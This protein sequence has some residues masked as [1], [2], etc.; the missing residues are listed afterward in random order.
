MGLAE[1]ILGRDELSAARLI[2]LIENGDDEAY[3][4]IAALF[5][6]AG[7]AHVIGITGPA[8]AG[9]STIT[10]KLA[11]QYAKSGRKVG[12]LAVDPTSVHGG[13]ALLG[14]RLRMKEAEKV[15]GI[16]IR[17]M[18]SRGYPGGIARA[19][20]GATYVLEALGKDLILVESVGAGQSD[21]A[22][23][24]SSD[25][26]ITL[27]TPDY[28]DEIQLLKAGLFEIGDI[29]VLNKCDLPGADATERGLALF[30]SERHTGEWSVPVI[31][32]C[33]V[34][35]EGFDKLLAAI[36]AHWAQLE[37][38]REAKRKE[39]AAV[40]FMALLKEELWVRFLER[41]GKTDEF[42]RVREKVRSGKIDPYNATQ[43]LLEGQGS[44]AR[45]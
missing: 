27:F 25:T 8:G 41:E 22:L 20:L 23:E 11:V 16:Y 5:P 38:A 26:V 37:T 39:R 45:H 40:F 34:R 24:Y 36:D 29:V 32:T 28:G 12:I 4:E 2:S 42:E 35:N 3:A 10:G 44:G 18:A 13:G 30:F 17:S 31:A 9:K 33:A 15:A 19:V 21:K 43:Q 7:R 1:K 6:H 14:D